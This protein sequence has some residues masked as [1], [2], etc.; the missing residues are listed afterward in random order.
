MSVRRLWMASCSRWFSCSILILRALS[1]SAVEECTRATATE[2]T[3]QQRRKHEI[4]DCQ[5]TSGWFVTSQNADNGVLSELLIGRHHQ[6]QRVIQGDVVALQFGN[7]S[8]DLVDGFLEHFLVLGHLHSV[9]DQ[10]T[11]RQS[12]LVNHISPSVNWCNVIGDTH[13]AAT[14]YFSQSK[15]SP[16]FLGVSVPPFSGISPNLNCCGPPPIKFDANP[17]HQFVKSRR[18]RWSFIVQ[19]RDLPTSS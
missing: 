13:T 19:T 6:F 8:F 16:R 15:R 7:Q 12:W 5:H 17:R 18:T 10:Q 9:G 3:G 1:S 2:T 11:Q 4:F 14:A